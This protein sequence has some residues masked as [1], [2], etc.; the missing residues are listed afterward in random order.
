MMSPL[1]M[2]G[3]VMNIGGVWLTARR[4]MLCWPVGIVGVL[5]YGYLF[6]CW[7]LYGDM[8]LQG[9]YVV[10]QAYGWRHW[11][12][13]PG[14]QDARPAPVRSNTRRLVVE[15]VTTCA[16]SALLAWVMA[17]RTDDAMPRIDAT[18]T[19]FSLLAAFWAARRHV[20]NWF[21]WVMVDGAYTVLFFYR[22]D[23]LTAFLYGT[24]TV[25]A[26]YGAVAWR[27]A[28]RHNAG[29]TGYRRRAEA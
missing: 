8:A 7:K 12:G 25:L 16:L 13:N 5:V 29:C 22:Q 4:N 24:F 15:I 17:H 10:L 20:E 1:E 2:S 3:V 26:I 18:L 14:A 27:A 28:A 19:C 11:R 21:L 9:V 6:W 23:T